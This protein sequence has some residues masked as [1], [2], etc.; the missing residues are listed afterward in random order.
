[1]DAR[2]WDA[3]YA[4]SEFLWT[5]EANRFLTSEV[6]G[7]APGAALDVGCGE[8]RNAVWLAE[9]GWAVTGVDFS[10]VGLDKARWL[11]KA[12]DVHVTWVEADLLHYEPPASS[13]ELVTVLYLHLEPADLAA[14]L[15][16]SAAAVAP[17]GSFL[18][19]GHSLTN[20]TK[21]VGGPQMPGI[22]HTKERVEAGLGSLEIVRSE[23]VTR[24]VETVSGPRPAIDY[25]VRARR[26]AA[27]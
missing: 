6:D 13:F 17:G 7:L 11:A 21:G 26:R 16:R 9:Q 2:D 3:R 5:V 20:L 19:V 23:E 10:P 15:E 22:L 12:R 24:A 25:L 4:E 14:V 1:M 18:S 8:G 27:S